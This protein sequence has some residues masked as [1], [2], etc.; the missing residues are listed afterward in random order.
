MSDEA[1]VAL[2]RDKGGRT[3][4]GACRFVPLFH[5]TYS[6]AGPQAFQVL[7]QLA[8]F[9]ASTGVVSEKIFMETAMRGLST[10]PCRGIARQV[11]A[12]APL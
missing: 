7:H 3:G 1:R 2:K 12:S 5:E 9:A 6:L 11:L 4:T 8:E 10:T